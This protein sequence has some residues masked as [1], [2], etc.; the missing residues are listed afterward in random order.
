MQ[1]ELKRIQTEVGITFIYVTH[2]QEEAMTMSDRLAV[3]RGGV[4]EQIG[5]PASVYE[6]PATE[7]V[8]GFLGASNLLEGEVKE[9]RGDNAL[10]LLTDGTSVSAPSS[11]VDGDVGTTVKVGVRPEKVTLKAD[12]T[13]TANGSNSISGL[14]RTATYIGVS[15]QYTV[16]GPE[17]ATLTVYAQ[18]LGTESIPN[19]GE[20]VRLEW[21]PE[22]TFAVRPQADASA[23]LMEELE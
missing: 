10:I 21:E 8:A 15:Y 13:P 1:L 16:E 17:G 3:M 18:N 5:A 2:D 7:F 9:V 14:L 23:L 19:P 20:K 4:I 22:F 12:S 11:R 6:S